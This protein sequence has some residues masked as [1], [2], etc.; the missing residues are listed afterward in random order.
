MYRSYNKHDIERVLKH[1]EIY[2]RL[3]GNPPPVETYHINPSAYIFLLSDDGD[4]LVIVEQ[5]ADIV[6][7]FH[8]HVIPESRDNASEYH[9]QAIDWVRENTTITKLVTEVPFI[10]LDVVNFGLKNGWIIEGINKQS[11]LKGGL[12]YDQ[13]YLGYVW[14][15]FVK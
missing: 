2:P 7:E 6:G 5:K 10:Y 8:F 9:S 15:L 12:I 3:S 1:P 13:Y 11:Y 4:C 14:D